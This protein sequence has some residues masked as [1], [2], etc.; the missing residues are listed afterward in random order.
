MRISSD[1]TKKSYLS[2]MIADEYYAV[3]V[4]KVL[5]VLQI[6]KLTEIPRM[7]KYF[8]GIINFRGDVLPV[9]DLRLKFNLPEVE[10]T[11]KT[12]II[13]LDI[14][15]NDDKSVLVGGIADAV[16]D[17]IEI[18]DKEIL[19]LPSFERQKHAEFLHGMIK[20]D[21]K[22]ILLLKIDEI[23]SSDD[24]ALMDIKDQIVSDQLSD[25]FFNEPVESNT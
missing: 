14:R 4:N 22:F 17:V 6:Q 20:S 3:N 23:F 2:F 16:K 11:T 21:E 13:V 12:I 19:M 1:A 9:I 10:Y 7:P 25:E 18:N 8:R 15:L 5:E 24:F